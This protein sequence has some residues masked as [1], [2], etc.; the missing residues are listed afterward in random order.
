ML[1]QLQMLDGEI[2]LWLQEFVRCP[3]LDAV[4][5]PFTALGNSGLLWIVLSVLMLCFPK[6]RKAGALTLL[7]LLV[8]ALATNLTLK[9]W[10]ARPRPWLWVEGLVPMLSP[11][12]P[13]S[14]PSG[15]T[16]AAFAAAGIWCRTLPRRWMRVAALIQAVVMAFSRLYAGVHFPTDVLGGLCVGLLG[17]W[18]VWH[19]YGL[20]RERSGAKS[21]RFDNRA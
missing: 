20:W 8:G 14:F 11:G 1:D 17:S 4:L 6:T 16:T 15:H 3:V 9:P 5:I 12:D 19:G 13:Y 21:D 2:L 18:L 7:A 10:A